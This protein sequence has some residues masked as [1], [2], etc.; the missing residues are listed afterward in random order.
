MRQLLIT[1]KHTGARA[2]VNQIQRVLI[3]QQHILKF[4]VAVTVPAVMESLK[5]LYHFVNYFVDID[6]FVCVI[7]FAGANGITMVFHKNLLLFVRSF[8]GNENWKTFKN[9]NSFK[10]FQLFLKVINVF[11]IAINLPFLELLIQPL[12]GHS[13]K[14]LAP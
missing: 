1:F 2:E 9:L 13:K 10:Y 6:W 11:F 12:T 5:A 4:D 14:S 3:R 8:S 7:P